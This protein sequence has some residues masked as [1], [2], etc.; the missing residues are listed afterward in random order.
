VSSELKI[1]LASSSPRREELISGLGLEFIVVEP[2]SDESSD[3]LDPKVRVVKNAEAK[4]KSISMQFPKSII[5][6]ADTIVYI[7]DKFLGKPED[8]EEAK[9]ILET[10]SDKTHKVFTGIAILDT[11]TNNMKSAFDE[12][13]VSFKK[14]S[15]I[16]I[17]E[18]VKTGESL[19][20][21]GAYAIQG[22]GMDFVLDIKGSY[23]N[24]VGLPVELLRE[25]LQNFVDQ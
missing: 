23:S 5:I 22:K 17:D 1:V 19:D 21:A 18:Y 20:K 25:L 16:E 7:N 13:V 15:K 10:L 14:I 2:A 6:G 3:H 12:T 11:S 4:V 8:I 24:V 9:Q